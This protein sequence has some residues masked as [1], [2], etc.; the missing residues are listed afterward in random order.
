MSLLLS[1]GIASKFEH[2]R[3]FP[4][5]HHISEVDKQSVLN[6]T[7]YFAESMRQSGRIRDLT[8]VTI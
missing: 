7:G 3:P 8:E 2:L 4:Q 1:T 5:Q 6:H